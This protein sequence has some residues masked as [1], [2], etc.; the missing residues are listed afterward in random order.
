VAS[1]RKRKDGEEGRLTRGSL[2]RKQQR[3]G[4]EKTVGVSWAGQVEC[5]DGVWASIGLRRQDC[6]G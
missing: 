2:R 5:W 6:R 1:W 3:G 4:Q